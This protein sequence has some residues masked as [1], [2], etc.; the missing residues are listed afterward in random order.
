LSISAQKD[1]T[2]VEALKGRTVTD[3]PSRKENLAH[4][5]S[6]E[7]LIGRL[8][9]LAATIRSNAIGSI[10][11]EVVGIDATATALRRR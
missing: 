3:Y 2:S 11:A 4:E 6:F 8:Q 10:K 7:S 5:L 1:I 9:R